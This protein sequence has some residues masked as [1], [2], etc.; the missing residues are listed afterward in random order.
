MKIQDVAN[1][2]S[3][4]IVQDKNDTPKNTFS[5]MEETM[6]DTFDH[7][8]DAFYNE[9]YLKES[10]PYPNFRFSDLE[11]DPPLSECG[12]ESGVTITKEQLKDYFERSKFKCQDLVITPNKGPGEVVGVTMGLDYTYWYS[13][14]LKGWTLKQFALPYKE[15]HLKDYWGKDW[16]SQKAL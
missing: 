1:I 13:I 8:G 5:D 14:L 16:R 3:T 15:E 7:F 4:I 6:S 2:V 11:T 9:M 10:D 12:E